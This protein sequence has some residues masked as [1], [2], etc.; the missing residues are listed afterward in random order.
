MPL[1]RSETL[2]AVGRTLDQPSSS[3]GSD[4]GG[5]KSRRPGT[6]LALTPLWMR[7][8]VP[9]G[10]EQLLV[11]SANKKRATRSYCVGAVF[12][13]GMTVGFITGK[14]FAIGGAS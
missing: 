12:G 13:T 7:F 11:A 9:R 2:N 4:A 5:T 6:A 8:S 14:P 10:K 1:A 3:I